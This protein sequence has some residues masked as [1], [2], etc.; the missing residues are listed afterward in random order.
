MATIVSFGNDADVVERV[1]AAVAHL[2][3]LGRRDSRVACSLVD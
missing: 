1:E 2:S 3:T